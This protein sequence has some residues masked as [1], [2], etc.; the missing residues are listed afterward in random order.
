MWRRLEK[1]CVNK[2]ETS[3]KRKLKK[4]PKET[5]EL[6]STIIETKNSIEGFKGRFEQ[7]EKYSANLRAG[8]GNWEKKRW[9]KANKTQGNHRAQSNQHMHHEVPEGEQK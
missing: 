5:L 4:Y 1:Q 3:I 7:T 2:I 6:K 8:N 9:K